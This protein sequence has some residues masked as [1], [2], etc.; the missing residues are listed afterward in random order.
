[1]ATESGFP[2]HATAPECQA[3]P[4]SALNGLDTCD[5]HTPGQAPCPGH[6]LADGFDEIVFCD[7][8]CGADR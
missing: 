4:N 8:P 3:C 7:D 1:M 5:E 6:P 2:D